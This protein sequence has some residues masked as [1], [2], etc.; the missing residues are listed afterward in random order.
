MFNSILGN[1]LPEARGYWRQWHK[2]KCPDCG[3]EIRAGDLRQYCKEHSI[4][5]SKEKFPQ[6]CPECGKEMQYF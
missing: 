3:F 1:I 6:P 5:Y 4:P 2:W